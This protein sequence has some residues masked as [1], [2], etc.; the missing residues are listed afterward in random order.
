VAREV[1]ATKYSQ[2]GQYSN[3]DDFGLTYYNARWYDPTIARFVQPDSMVP[4]GVQGY[5]RYAY[6][7]NN[8]VNNSDPTGHCA[9]PASATACLA[10]IPAGPVGWAVIGVLVV[11][12]VVLVTYIVQT[13]S[14]PPEVGNTIVA[15][16]FA[17]VTI[18][19][20]GDTTSADAVAEAPLQFAHKPDIGFID[21]LEK[22]YGLNKTER[23]ILH[24]MITRQGLSRDEIEREAAEMIRGRLQ[25]QQEK[26]P[27]TQAPNDKGSA[28][29]Q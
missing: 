23:R 24:D 14:L 6:A 26:K 15:S 21:Y 16:D 1:I 22:K 3:M 25:K 13:S 7:N 8:P 19:Q 28:E 10:L 29:A 12:D 5:D 18:G 20:E 9:D 27:K 2:T 4:G 11:V 17:S